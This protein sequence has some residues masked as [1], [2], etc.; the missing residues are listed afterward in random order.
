MSCTLRIP[1]ASL[2]TLEGAIR[3]SQSRSHSWKLE[4]GGPSAPQSQQHQKSFIQRQL[5]WFLLAWK[6]T[7]QKNIIVEECEN[8]AALYK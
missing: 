8:L 1:K 7:E 2:S 3:P 6:E 4:E 5:R